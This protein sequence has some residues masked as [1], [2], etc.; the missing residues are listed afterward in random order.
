MQIK[1]YQEKA[2]ETAVYPNR[3]SNLAY[4]I[5]GLV[6]EAGEL[7]NKLKKIM[8]DKHSVVTREDRDS[9]ASELGDVLWY[10]A[11]VA[12]EIGIPLSEI[13]EENLGKLYS[14]KQRGA[15]KGSGDNR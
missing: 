1:H 10:V 13:A 5:I 12:D 6:G 8:R 11:A 14:R 2:L 7:A 4:A 15:L 3:G 9:L